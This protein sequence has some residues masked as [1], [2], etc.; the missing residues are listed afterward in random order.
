MCKKSLIV[1]YKVKEIMH[2]HIPRKGLVEY[3]TKV[4]D[5]N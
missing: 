1:S 3:I 5:K 2:N 4:V